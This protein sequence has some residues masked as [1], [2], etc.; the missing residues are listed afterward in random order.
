M[1]VFKAVLHSI[2]EISSTEE[3]AAKVNSVFEQP[4]QIMGWSFDVRGDRPHAMAISRTNPDALLTIVPATHAAFRAV[5]RFPKTLEVDTFRMKRCVAD[6]IASHYP[7]R[8]DI[9]G[10][11]LRVIVMVPWLPNNPNNN[12]L[13]VVAGYLAGL[14]RH[15]DVEDVLLL[16]T[17]ETA[18]RAD[19][20]QPEARFDARSYLSTHQNVAVEFGAKAEQVVCA[21]PPFQDGGNVAWH[22][23]LLDS[24]QPNAVFVPNFEMTSAH[25]HGFG[26]SCATVYLQTSVRN[27]PPYDF[28][29]YLYLGERRTIDASH[30]HPDR[31]HYHT[32]GYERFGAG[33]ALSRADIGVGETDFILVSAGN[34]LEVEIN[35]EIGKIV[36]QTMAKHG[37]VKWMLLGTQDADKIRA[38]LGSTVA[39]F[40]DRLIFKGYVK[41]VGDYLGLCDVYVNPRRTG[42]AVSMALAVYGGTPVMSF[43]GNDAGNFLVKDMICA[44]PA[45]YAAQLDRLAGDPTYLAT[46]EQLQ[47][48][49][50]NDHHTIDASVADLVGH[51]KAALQDRRVA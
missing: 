24:F 15:P 38:N 47:R 42:G 12:I 34:R 13:R 10:A 46:I 3:V 8:R 2:G 28:T 45:V 41:E 17:N 21:P 37:R 31:W 35:E 6:A 27:R 18:T 25:I 16:I 44:S 36:A 1:Q 29:R 43:T 11:P 22:L 4:L 51:L 14:N 32:F 19:S 49:R 7:V 20:T 40:E 9:S 48:T 39:G 23:K 50:F 5:R 33:S 26:R 30:I